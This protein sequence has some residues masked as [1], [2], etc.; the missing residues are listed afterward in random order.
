M[1]KLFGLVAICV[2]YGHSPCYD[3]LLSLAVSRCASVMLNMQLMSLDV[4][5]QETWRAG[6]TAAGPP[7][8][9]MEQLQGCCTQSAA[10]RRRRKGL[11]VGERWSVA[12][13]EEEAG[14]TQAAGLWNQA[15]G[16][17][18]RARERRKRERQTGRRQRG[19]GT[20]PLL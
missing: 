3:A 19:E 11:R 4:V 5:E 6:L 17:R 16:A 9:S 13:P 1:Q 15:G 20:H 2:C 10:A 8:G 14:M 7:A 12:E 18:E